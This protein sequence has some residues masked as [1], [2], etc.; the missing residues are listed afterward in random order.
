MNMKQALERFLLHKYQ[1]LKSLPELETSEATLH[2]LEV[3]LRFPR[4]AHEENARESKKK[5]K[6]LLYQEVQRRRNLGESIRGI[7]FALKINRATARKYFDAE[8]FPERVS[9][10]RRGSLLDPFLPYL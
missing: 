2:T 7:S 10:R 1:E 8:R 6:I 4:S 5:E 9:H 3:P